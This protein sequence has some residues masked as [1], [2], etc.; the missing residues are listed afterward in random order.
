MPASGLRGAFR[1]RFTLWYW[2]G[3]GRDHEVSGHLAVY[4]GVDGGPYHRAEVAEKMAQRVLVHR[5]S[6][7]IWITREVLELRERPRAS[8]QQPSVIDRV[9]TGT[10]VVWQNP[11]GAFPSPPPEAPR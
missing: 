11:A 9:W 10:G 6:A 8:P 1:E 2:D 7:A 4:L 3:S 5:P